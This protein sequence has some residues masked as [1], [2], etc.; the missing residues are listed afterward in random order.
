M[1]RHSYVFVIS[2]AGIDSPAALAG[3]RIGV[4][5]YQE[6]AGVWIRGILSRSYGVDF[7][8]VSW[9]ESGVDAPR[10]PDPAI[11][12][13]PAADLDITF[14]GSDTCLDEWL[15][16]GR[17]DAYFGARG[18]QVVR[19]PRVGKGVGPDMCSEAYTQ[20]PCGDER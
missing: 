2:D 9:F 6:T 16:Q 10:Q 1:F 18:P 13:R 17:I 20:Q 14:I 4:Q 3:K 7:S 12:P 19:H 15:A 11:V 5:E 8:A